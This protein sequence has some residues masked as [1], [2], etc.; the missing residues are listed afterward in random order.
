MEFASSDLVIVFKGSVVGLSFAVGASARSGTLR[1][2]DTDA[3]AGTLGSVTVTAALAF[4]VVCS[5][6]EYF[7][8]A[9]PPTAAITKAVISAGRMDF[10]EKLP[11]VP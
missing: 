6:S 9:T 1:V 11:P 4:S 7:H 10:A 5:V 8:I 3:V 2:A